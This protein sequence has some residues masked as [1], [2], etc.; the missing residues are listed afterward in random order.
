MTAPTRMFALPGTASH[1]DDPALI[2]RDEAHLR[3]IADSLASARTAAAERLDRVRREPAEGGQATLDRDL[4]VHRLAAELSTLRRFGADLC[5]G[6]MVF[7]GDPEPVYIGRTGLAGPD[8]RRLLVDWRS[9]AA[10]PFF[11]ATT[12]HPMGLVRRRRYRWTGAHVTDYWD[13]ALTS[14]PIDAALDDQSAFIASLGEA[15]TGRMRDVLTTLQADQDAIIRADSRGALV[16]DGGPGTG[17]TVVALHRAALLLY[18]D[19]RLGRGRGGVLVVGPSEPYLAYV[20]DVLPALGED[21]VQTC[22]LADLVPGG[23]DA[24]A[25]PDARVAALKGS[26]ALADAIERAVAYHENAPD[27]PMSVS[28]PWGEVP[29]V[30]D[31]WDEAF[32]APDPGTSHNEARA[33]VWEALLEILIDRLGGAAPH[34]LAHRTLA[35]TAELGAAMNRAWPLLDPVGVVADLW[36]VPAYLRRCAP[37]L[38][39]EEVALL[40]R[41]DPRAWST[42]DVPLLDAAR[43]RIGDPDRERRR[44]RQDAAVAAERE[45]FDDVIEALVDA[46][47]DGEGL[48]TML[49]GS[50]AR[51]SLLDEDRLRR[52]DPDELA[53]PF[54]H[55]I[56]DE[57][58]DLTDAQWRM[59]R[60]RCPSGSFTIV[61]DRAQAQAGFAG[62]WEDRLAAAGFGRV[63]VETL[64]INYRTPV[65]VMAA[66]EPV[67]RSVLPDANVPTS[68][69]RTGIP[70]RYA[71]RAERDSIVA[72]WT[73]RHPEGTACVIGDPGFAGTARVR[74]L[75]P[76]LAK[77]LEFDAVIL[78]GPD[79]LGGVE[80][81][82]AMTRAT[83]QLVV[84]D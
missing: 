60:D 39:A 42:A 35:R 44:L 47:D 32:A 69:R 59:L 34:G 6:Q 41:D 1:K 11:A 78:V 73:A 75:S 29:V 33:I 74:S 64:T 51:T 54:G 25:E 24:A 43:R 30:P 3:A 56:V 53:G 17:K 9:P 22:T 63:R 15:R 72:A 7:A 80:R 76:A 28:T 45:R 55:I 16:V 48:V 38:S 10:E 5:L 65:E 71:A 62:S 13:E 49:T 52:L 79:R 58:Q 61:G 37:A 4:E 50:D 46:D 12:T 40:Q 36:S 84:L 57:A 14:G 20:D 2:G 23:R 83:E 26:H 77:G 18:S 21:G 81:Y 67:I 19:P 8:G 82:V 68:V 27:E 66:A 31:D 70:V